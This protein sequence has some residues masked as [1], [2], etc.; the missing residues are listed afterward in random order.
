MEKVAL[1][2][3]NPRYR[4]DAEHE[5]ENVKNVHLS[6]HQEKNLK[7]QRN[8]IIRKYNEVLKSN[9]N[10]NSTHYERKKQ[11]VRTFIAKPDGI[12]FLGHSKSVE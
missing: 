2:H 8:Q 1:V 10:H 3:F 7:V 12:M 5:G 4:C 11:L 6:T 9:L